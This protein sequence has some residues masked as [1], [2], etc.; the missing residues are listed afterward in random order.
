VVHDW[1][2]GAVSTLFRR[3]AEAMAATPPATGVRPRLVVV[4]GELGG[5]PRDDIATRSDLLM[6]ALT[7]GGQERT[8]DELARLA[9]EAGLSLDRSIA[10]ASGDRAY[11]FSPTAI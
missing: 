1:V 11:V 5:R 7:P 3:V 9:G 2:D 4:E 6:L 10:L 8:A